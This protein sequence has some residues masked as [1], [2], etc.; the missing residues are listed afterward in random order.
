MMEEEEDWLQ[1]EAAQTEKLLSSSLL[2]SELKRKRKYF[3]SFLWSG[4]SVA[5][6]LHQQHENMFNN[7]LDSAAF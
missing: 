2:L 5:E 4:V 3:I 6:N 7:V 1:A